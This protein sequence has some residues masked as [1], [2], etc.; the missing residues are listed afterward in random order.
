VHVPSPDP[1]VNDD[2]FAVAAKADGD[3]WAVGTSAGDGGPGH[4]L[5]L[6]CC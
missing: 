5:A 3:A 4:A 6:H 1:A 2:L